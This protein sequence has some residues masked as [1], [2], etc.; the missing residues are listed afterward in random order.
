MEISAGVVLFRKEGKKVLFLVLHYPKTNSGDGHWEF[1]KGHV[2]KVIDANG[3]SRPE[4]LKET[5]LRE[6][7]EETG[8]AKASIME[9]FKQEIRYFFKRQGKP[10]SKKVIF[11]LAETQQKQVKLSF[12]H[13]GF[14]WLQYEEALQQVTFKNAKQILEKSHK[15]LAT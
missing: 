7:K 6:L 9:G 3:V 4:S 11:F 13:K 15:F 14:K 5:A 2:E 12:E 10:V 1:P 8:I